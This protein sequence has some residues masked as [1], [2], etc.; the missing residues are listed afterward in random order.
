MDT[1]V[2]A[3]LD[4]KLVEHASTDPVSQFFEW[5][6]NNIYLKLVVILIFVCLVWQYFYQNNPVYMLISI[7]YE[8]IIQLLTPPFKFIYHTVLE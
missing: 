2:I 4:P 6:I 3:K 5:I 1:E 8:L 7:L